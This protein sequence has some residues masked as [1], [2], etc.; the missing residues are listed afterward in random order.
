MRQRW[1]KNTAGQVCSA[2]TCAY[3]LCCSCKWKDFILS[4]VLTCSWSVI[5]CLSDKW[6]GGPA[7]KRKTP[8]CYCYYIILCLGNV[9]QQIPGTR[10]PW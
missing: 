6:S 7:C 8:I 3:I 1:Q 5:K 10:W 4:A 2:V 9:A